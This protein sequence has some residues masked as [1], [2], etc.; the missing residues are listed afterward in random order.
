MRRSSDKCSN[1]KHGRGKAEN[2]GP[3]ATAALGGGARGSATATV[4]LLLLQLFALDTMAVKPANAKTPLASPFSTRASRRPTVPRPAPLP[5]PTPLPLV[6][7]NGGSAPNFV[8]ILTD[9]QDEVLNS[10]HPA[11]MP[12]LNYLLGARGTRFANTLV[13]TSVCCP[14]RV[15][16]LTGRLAHCSNVTAN[17]AP[18]GAWLKFSRLGLDSDWLPGWL[19]KAGYQTALVGKLL[20][21]FSGLP[22]SCPHGFDHLD[23]L[24]DGTYN[25]YN[26]T[27]SLNCA[28]SHTMSG[29]YQTD[30][31]RDKA[32]SYLE[33]AAA[34][35]APFYLQLTPA[36][37]HVDNGG[38]N[39]WR[40]PPPAARHVD[41]YPDVDLP[42]NPTFLKANPLNPSRKLDMGN[43]DNVKAMTDLYV[44]R[45]RAL[46]AVDEMVAA[47]VYKLLDLGILD[48][49]YIVYMSDN[50]YHMGQH[51]LDDGKGTPLEEDSRV[52][53][54][55]FG[56]GV[57]AGMVS[58]YQANLVDLA[59]TVLALAGLPP[60]LDLD[61]LPLPLEGLT[62]D[63]YAT[64]M[65]QAATAAARRA[66]L[67]P[68]SPPL[69][70]P[71][72]PAPPWQPDTA[73][74]PRNRT[75]V[76]SETNI[77]RR[78]LFPLVGQSPH[79]PLPGIPVRPLHEQQL[80]S[81]QSPSPLHLPLSDP[82]CPQSPSASANQLSLEHQRSLVARWSLGLPQ[83]Q[84]P[85]PPFRRQRPPPRAPPPRPR[86]ASLPSK[87]RSPIPPPFPQPSH[88]LQVLSMQTPSPYKP[89]LS[90][91]PPPYP[92]HSPP[93]PLPPR[94]P[95]SLRR[96]DP[97]PPPPVLIQSSSPSPVPAQLT[98]W[99]RPTLPSTI[100]P[101][102]PSA[103]PLPLPSSLPSPIPSPPLLSPP[104]TPRPTP[105]SLPLQQ[106]QPPAALWLREAVILEAW[107]SDAKNGFFPGI[108]FK[109]LR[110]C[111]TYQYNLRVLRSTPSAG[112]G[113]PMQQRSS[114]S[115]PQ[116]LSHQ[117]SGFDGLP[118]LMVPQLDNRNPL[119]CL[120]YVVWCK[121]NQRELYDLT[122][123]PY[124]ETNVL[125]S[126]P[127]A[128]LDRLNAVLS[129][130]V[131]CRG[132]D[133]S[134]PYAVLHPAGEVVTF[135]Q[136]M[137]PRYDA[138][139]ASLPRFAFATCYPGY[140]PANERTFTL[141]LQGFPANVSWNS[142][143]IVWPLPPGVR[144]IKMDSG[145]K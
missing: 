11:Y 100:T 18:M 38:G 144:G 95:S 40:P 114:S 54:F 26:S 130:L 137:E 8:V 133:C 39:G 92:L 12:A 3:C 76:L 51:G 127:A 56:P 115:P 105:H 122:Y 75:R 65:H 107:D 110:L 52:P 47:I 41:L 15:S 98:G 83:P 21:G 104:P 10:T 89:P 138:L 85:Q 94:P 82:S 108:T 33:A 53:L 91:S 129:V 143:G 60:R 43:R 101:P 4:I 116:P 106:S 113:L 73:R 32:L 80:T 109:G 45:L 6:S 141:G 128:L 119:Y 112:S 20:N 126:A 70:P 59:P 90:L 84:P 86:S 87:P 99:Q 7:R 96:P 120:K 50:G 118:A 123:D 93:P 131:H 69:M 79:P 124:E 61:G 63:A 44:G 57:A 81:P 102:L 125:S 145:E 30:I 72:P 62:I 37:P 23:A 121:G 22:Y 36:A 49:T 134:H 42:P 77:S 17:W 2:R 9:D 132:A 139:Y 97:L 71:M 58:T 16:L 27:F 5:Q 142:T 34:S 74:P 78:P 136:T 117:Q 64:A 68:P 140:V 25:F 55:L 14:A 13:S 1:Y 48:N 31:I 103:V 28:T 135:A 29:L 46:R 88:N 35:R 19:Q 66:G 24:T 67:R 111:S